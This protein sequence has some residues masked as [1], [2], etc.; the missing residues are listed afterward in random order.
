ME[1]TPLKREVAGK[2]PETGRNAFEKLPD[3][4]R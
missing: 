4:L 2:S 3:Y 1:D